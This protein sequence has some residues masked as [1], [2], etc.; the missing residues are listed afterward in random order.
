MSFASGY[1]R[2]PGEENQVRPENTP[3]TVPAYGE[4]FASGADVG[5]YGQF[6]ASGVEYGQRP[7]HKAL[8]G[9]SEGVLYRM[10]I[11]ENTEIAFDIR[12]GFSQ[13]MLQLRIVPESSYN[14]SLADQTKG[15][16]VWALLYGTGFIRGRFLPPYLGSWIVLIEPVPASWPQQKRD[17]IEIVARVATV[18]LPR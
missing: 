9:P 1:G 12:W 13:I 17:P 8:V 2:R 18:G 15:V 10:Q 3:F 7:T 6:L 16:S 4:P 11:F 5:A 14:A